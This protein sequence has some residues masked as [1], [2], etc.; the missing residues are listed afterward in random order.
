MQFRNEADPKNSSY[1]DLDFEIKGIKERQAQMMSMIESLINESS[2]KKLY[3]VNDLADML[4]VSRRTIF[5][6]KM[7]GT[8][9]CT[10]VGGKI[11]VSDAQLNEFLESNSN[12]SF[13]VNS[14]R[15]QKGV[16][17]HE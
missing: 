6:W 16:P 1:M 3:D 17:V 11:W 13:K 4:K 5:T 12:A 2:Q 9:P 10:Q 14:P 8:L 15:R 7:Q